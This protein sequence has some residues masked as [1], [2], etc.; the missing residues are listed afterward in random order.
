MLGARATRDS[1]SRRQR[2]DHAE[3]F[4]KHYGPRMAT[5]G[6]QGT[7]ERDRTNKSL[8][9]ERRKADQEVGA[10]HGC[11]EER[12]REVVD[13]ARGQADDVLEAARTKATS[14][15]ESSGASAEALADAGAEQ[16]KEDTALDTERRTADFLLET[17][18]EQ[19][20]RALASLLGVERGKTDKHL[21][22]ERA[23]VDERLARIFEELA[24]AVRLRD[25]FVALASHELNTPLTS[26]SLRLQSLA[27]ETVRHPDSPFTRHVNDYIEVAKGQ[28]KKFS[29]LVADLLDVSRIASRKLT[30]DLESV[31]FGAI[32]LETV[33]VYRQQAAT[34]GSVLE[35][36]APR[37]MGRWDELLLERTVSNLL[38]NAIKFGRGKPMRVRLRATAEAARLTVQDE[39]IGIAAEHLSRIFGRFERAVSSRNYGGLGLG[40]YVCRTIVEAMDGTIAVQS[41]LG[42]GSTFTVE[43]PLS[44]PRVAPT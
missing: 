13:R 6:T 41:E 31:D 22:L 32:V 21:L 23:L 1:T 25:E 42:T 4:P 33:A 11:T 9:A 16:A 37:I 2:A 10:T 20:R 8:R 24:E 28:A 5:K 30:L 7:P 18:R 12:A 40:L 29:T 43:L 38:E 34:A 14:K 3:R 26:L 44:G 39:G 15:L 35:V 17:Q 19:R 36:D 27:R